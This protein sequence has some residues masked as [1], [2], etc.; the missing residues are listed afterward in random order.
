MDAKR[1]EQVQSIF[2]KIVDTD[3]SRQT[4]LLNELCGDDDELK[5]EVQSLLESD[6]ENL[7]LLEKPAADL[8]NIEK[9]T[10]LV[11]KTIGQYHIIKQIGHGGMGEVY[12][13][14]RDD[15]QFDQRVALKIVKRGMNS[16]DTIRR[17]QAERQILA[18]LDHPNIARLYDGGVTD[19]GLLYF[20]MEYIEGQP[21]NQYCDNHQLTIKERLTLFKEVIDAIQYAHKNFIVHRDLKPGNIIVTTDGKIKLLDFGIAKLISENEY[22]DYKPEMTQT[23]FRVMTPGYASPEQ[24]KGQTITTASDVY[25]LGVVLYELLTGQSPYDIS[26]KSPGE[27]E[28]IICHTDPK[29]PSTTVGKQTVQTSNS[30]FSDEIAERRKTIPDKLKKTLR[31]DLD[32]ICLKTL[33]KEQER[34]YSSAEQLKDDIN[35]YLLGLP[36]LARPT[37]VTYRTVKFVKRHKTGVFSFTAILLLIIGLVSFYT[38]KLS[39]ER[40]KAQLE[41]EKAKQISNYI[42][43]IFEIANPSESKGETITAR[44]ILDQG[45]ERIENELNDQPLVKADILAVISDVY[46]SLGMIEKSKNMMEEVLDIQLHQPDVDKLLLATNYHDFADLSYEMGDYTKA[47]SLYHVALDFKKAILPEDDTLIALEYI[48]LATVAR[49]DG[50]YDRA[51]SLYE[52]ALQI[53]NAKLE[54]PHADIAYT[55]NN[56]G[57]LYQNEGKYDKAEPLLKEGLEQRQALF[58]ELNVETIA[59]MGSLAS[60]Y[61]LTDRVEEAGELYSKGLANLKKIFGENHHYV[62]GMSQALG[63]VEIKLKHYK[64][65]EELLLKSNEILLKQLPKDNISIAPVKISLGHLYLE[66]NRPKKALEV[67]KE[68]YRIRRLSLPDDNWRV[69]EAK[70]YIGRAYYQMKDYKKAEDNLLP[71]Y[72]IFKEQFGDKNYRTQI[73]IGFICDLYQTQNS[74]ELLQKFEKLQKS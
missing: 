31:G 26:G 2:E 53:Q 41:A 50:E 29:K 37:T 18:N 60:L 58:G 47:D 57:R 15:K 14:E 24:I 10:S 52:N 43:S 72:N 17:F 34:R 13:A 22:I 46:Y 48:S 23:G 45:A 5:R 66:T 12:L 70:A 42:T 35:R 67:L 9:L 4:I 21:I 11:G 3:K 33:E 6:R 16:Q 59:S 44:E 40:D 49:I 25:S 68:G 19:D 56:L 55:M 74:P 63:N 51:E 38:M 27:F 7:S 69:A 73:V 39:R 28:Q 61:Y 64:K 8:I 54:K 62:G 71:A 32:N 30:G 36:V 65:A 20:T 1:W